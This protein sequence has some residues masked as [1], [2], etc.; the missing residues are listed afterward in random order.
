[1]FAPDHNG[2]PIK[3]MCLV[4][5]PFMSSGVPVNLSIG[6]I[7]YDGSG[8]DFKKGAMPESWVSLNFIDLGKFHHD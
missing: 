8:D 7:S 1:M 6:G 3:N 4:L 2:Y 5:D